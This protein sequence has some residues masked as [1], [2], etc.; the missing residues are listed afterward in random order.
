MTE[1]IKSSN[2]GGRREGA[3]HPKSE[4]EIFYVRIRLTREEWDKL[5][6][7]G[8]SKWVRQQLKLA[9]ESLE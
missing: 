7:L 2:W 9:K 6:R 8:G 1:E 4:K 5:K 3:G